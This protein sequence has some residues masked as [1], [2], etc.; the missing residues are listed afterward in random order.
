MGYYVN[1]EDINITVPKD[2][3]APAYQA[4]LAMNEHDDLKRGGSYG[5]GNERKAWFSWMPQDLSTLADL[6]EV[7]ETLGFEDTDYNESGDLVLGSYSNKTGQEDLFL[8]AIAPFVQEGSYAIWKGEDDSYYKW[9]FDDG[10]MLV[11]PGEVSIIWDRENA[12]SAM[13][14]WKRTQEMMEEFEMVTEAMKSGKEKD[15]A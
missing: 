4:V 1:T 7:L 10:K 14:D 11:I 15:N 9:E 6:K 2:L 13:D 12:Y 3:L 5:P 8:D